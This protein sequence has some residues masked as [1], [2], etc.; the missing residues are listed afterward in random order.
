MHP[1]QKNNLDAL[2]KRYDIDNSQRDLHGA[3]LDAE[4]LAETYLAMTGGQTMLSLG[5]HGDNADGLNSGAGVSNPRKVD[6]EAGQLRVLYANEEELNLHQARLSAINDSS[7]GNC[8]W[9]KEKQQLE[10]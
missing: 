4:I 8:V 6:I 9:L 10:Q 7:G 3:L 5:S 2:C 1:G